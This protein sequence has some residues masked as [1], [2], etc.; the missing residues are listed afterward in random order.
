[1]VEVDLES[2][3]GLTP[4]DKVVTAE[5]AIALIRDGD[6]VVAE[7]FAGQCFAEELTLALE[8]RFLQSGT[9][10]GLT[11]AFAVAQGNREGRG[12]DR[13]CYEG[14]LERAIGGHWGMSGALGKMAVDNKIEAYNLPQG[15]IAQLFRDTAAGKPGLL[16]R[17]GL[18]TFVD[19]R[20][21][22]G[23][24]N[25]KTTEDRVELMSIGGREYLFYKAFEDLDVAFLR[26][27]TADPN[28]NITMEHEGLYLE[29]LAVA[30]AVHNAGGLVI[31]QVERIA[32][33]G[34]LSAQDVKV[35]GVLVDCVVVSRPEHHTQTWGTAYSA[36]LS[37]ELRVPLSSVPALPMSIR[38]VIARRAAM[39]LRPNAVV[40]LGI[41]IPEGV[42]SVAAEERLLD[43]LVLT[44]E[45]GVIGG[46]PTGGLDFGCAINGDTILDQPAQ[47]DFYDGGGLDAA[48]LGMAQADAAGNVNVSRFGPKLAGSGGFINISQNAKKVVFL[49]SFLAPART[50]VV[51][52]KIVVADGVAAPK[53]LD[54]VEQRTFSGQYAGAAGQ[55]VLYVTERCV[56]RLV[57]DGLELIEIAPGVD[58]DKDVLAHVGFTP[59]I[60]GE[61]KLMDARIFRDEPMGLKEELLT[62]PLDMRFTYDA[63][64]NTFFINMEGMSVN[65]QTEAE[66]VVAEIDKRLAAVGKKVPVVVNYDNFD[67]TP[68]L[69]DYYAAA[70]RSLAERYY[71]NVT[72]YTTSSF[73]RLKLSGHLSQRGLAPH[74]YESRTE[75]LDR[76][77]K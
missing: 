15:V 23:K 42:A 55:P 69:V 12:F 43:Y 53:F 67:P 70:V 27:T 56:F 24:I 45:P 6:T 68:G 14:L 46:M 60:D 62:V 41:G 59:I 11:L 28:G 33:R 73:M 29:S 51:D 31:V 72:R 10:R 64:R 37:G 3:S 65:T 76:L 38:K 50:T 16:T 21:G 48:F 5:E 25:E 20:Q 58:L 52:G 2:L 36:A 1:M 18:G 26:G 32:E 77:N 74:I 22:G 7:G 66:A 19:P 30:T 61:P 57:P 13:L 47:F 8:A 71:E 49:G 39:E 44:A 54:S 35:P 9:P 34:A 40:N 4:R 75:A 17:V 63:E